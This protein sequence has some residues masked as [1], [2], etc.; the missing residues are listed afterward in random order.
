VDLYLKSHA[1][2]KDAVRAA[3]GVRGALAGADADEL[4]HEA[5][6][7]RSKWR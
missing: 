5:T 7:I 4:E 1:E 2:R 6:A 3:L